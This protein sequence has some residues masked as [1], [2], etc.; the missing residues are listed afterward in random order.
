MTPKQTSSVAKHAPGFGGSAQDG[1][2]KKVLNPESRKG[3]LAIG[4]SNV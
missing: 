4:E 1:G 2:L 3:S